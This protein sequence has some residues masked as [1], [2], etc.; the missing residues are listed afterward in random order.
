MK[1][2]SKFNPTKLEAVNCTISLHRKEVPTKP[3]RKGSSMSSIA[4]IASLKDCY[5]RVDR[6]LTPPM[7]TKSGA[8]ENVFP[9][10]CC[11]FGVYINFGG[12]YIRPSGSRV[13]VF[14]PVACLGQIRRIGG[15]PP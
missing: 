7:D 13:F 9:F 4:G 14:F 1:R 11:Y 5:M 15:L 10:K 6:M 2:K 3:R 12:L 8:L